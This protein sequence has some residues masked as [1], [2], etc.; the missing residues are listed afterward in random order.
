MEKRIKNGH[1]DL[2]SV[3]SRKRVAAQWFM[4]IKWFRRGTFLNIKALTFFLSRPY[5]HH[6]AHYRLSR[7]LGPS[8]FLSRQALTGTHTMTTCI[9][10]FFFVNKQLRTMTPVVRRLYRIQ[11]N[12]WASIRVPPR[13]AQYFCWAE[14]SLFFASKHILWAKVKS[15]YGMYIRLLG[16]ANHRRVP[17]SVN[18]MAQQ[19]F[20]LRFATDLELRETVWRR[21]MMMMTLY[22]RFL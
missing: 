9:Y 22:A 2:Y 13:V 7:A 8:L 17:G 1:L 15:I 21:L 10:P 16:R 11:N 5:R 14:H 20:K 12:A 19:C 6:I 4:T 3:L 18:E